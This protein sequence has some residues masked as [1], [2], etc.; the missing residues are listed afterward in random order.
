MLAGPDGAVRARVSLP[1]VR[2]TGVFG[3]LL[4]PDGRTLVTPSRSLDKA[5]LVDA[6][7]QGHFR[8]AGAR[9]S[10]RRAGLGG[11]DEVLQHAELVRQPRTARRERNPTQ[12]QRGAIVDLATGKFT[13]SGPTFKIQAWQSSVAFGGFLS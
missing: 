11:T 5:V 9:R 2:L 7:R 1:N 13:Y 10:R 12:E 3:N 4:S 8:A 6:H